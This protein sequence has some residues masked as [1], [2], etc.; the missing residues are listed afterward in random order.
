MSRAISF[1]IGELL[2]TISVLI[3]RELSDHFPHDKD[4][5][6]PRYDGLL[7]IQPPDTAASLRKYLLNL[8]TVKALNSKS[9]LAFYI[10]GSV[11]HNLFF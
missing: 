7:A 4:R 2:R 8:V 5:D 10:Y 6:G 11:H 9:Y 3:I 1:I